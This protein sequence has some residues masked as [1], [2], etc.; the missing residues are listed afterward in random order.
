MTSNH[1]CLSLRKLSEGF[2]LC[3]MAMLWKICYNITR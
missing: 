2:S 1:Y 3:L